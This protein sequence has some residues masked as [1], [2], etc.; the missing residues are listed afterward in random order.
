MQDIRR[1]RRRIQKKRSVGKKNRI[2]GIF[3]HFILLLMLV[4]V[5]SLSMMIATRLQLPFAAHAWEYVQSIQ[6]SSFLPFETWFQQETLE[7]VAA[8]DQ[9]EDLG[10]NRYRNGT[11]TVTSLFTGMILHIEAQN[12]TY[13]IS[14]LL[15]DGTLVNL[16]HIQEVSVQQEERIQAGASL[17]TYQEYIEIHCYLDGNEID[18]KDVNA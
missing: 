7:S 9:Y 14:L 1:I 6:W 8:V 4:C 13:C 3:N 17:G 16:S 18:L 12:D 15:D 5:L 11:N 2:V 10:Q